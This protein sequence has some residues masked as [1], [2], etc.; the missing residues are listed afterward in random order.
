MRNII[1]L[2]M[3]S[4]L[5]DVSTELVYPLLP[6]F[7]T[8]VLGAGPAVL[9][10]V[11]GIAESLASLTKVGFGYWSDRLGRRK[12]L[13]VAGYAL[14]TIG[15]LFL[16]LAHSWAWVLAGRVVDRFSKGVRTAPRDALVADSVPRERLGR[17]FGLHR[18]MDTLGASLGVL[19][20]YAFLR[21]SGG[22][23]RAAFL[24]AVLPG[25]LGL[26][27]FL[28]L[29]EPGQPTRGAAASA[30]AVPAPPRLR[31]TALPP[32]LKSFLLLAFL[33]SLGNSS[34]QFL[35]LRARNLG[36]TAETVVLLYLTYNLVYAAASYPAGRLADRLG[37][38]RVLVAGHLAFALVYAAFAAA[39]G[40][41]ALGGVF[42]AY[43]IY[44]ALTEGV[45]RAFLA[46]LAPKDLR[47]TVLGL[48]AT[49]VGV[50]LLPASLI[51][52]ALWETFGP[53]APFW[54]G[55]GTGFLATAGL[56]WLLRWPPAGA[57]KTSPGLQ[58]AP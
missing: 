3:V 29:R 19:G 14:A 31:W 44:S 52:G 5:T 40:V 58:L 22:D 43:G 51:A 37:H 17:A 6:L 53:E 9:G 26:V 56:L 32:T 4:L 1:L 28:P 30:A 8:E 34:N 48:H 38:G 46:E 27:F 55:A 49:F 15:K 45:V 35:L 33:F 39:D 7:L 50:A 16:V 20:A 23:V 13:A 24:W 10:L 25:V 2:G 54:F 42:A 18:A 12:P 41:T 21:L 36:A 57:A 47:A 11:E